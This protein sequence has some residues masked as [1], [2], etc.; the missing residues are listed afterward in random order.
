MF[1]S[2]L[3]RFLTMSHNHINVS[4]RALDF[5][6]KCDAVIEI[7]IV[8]CDGRTGQTSVPV[9]CF[10]KVSEEQEVAGP[11]SRNTR[12]VGQRCRVQA[13]ERRI[14]CIRCVTCN[15]RQ[16]AAF[17]LSRCYRENS[18]TPNSIFLIMLLHRE[19]EF[20]TCRL[21]CDAV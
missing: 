12:S 15:E 5:R 6:C 1:L 10:G 11:Y 17:T 2:P 8:Q 9:C 14:G 3:P 16:K 13:T 4:P 21:R 20:G 19:P 18:L 7:T